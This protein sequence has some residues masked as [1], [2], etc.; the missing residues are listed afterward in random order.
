MSGGDV[1]S[2][3]DEDALIV[4]DDE[5]VVRVGL[6]PDD[7]TVAGAQ[8]H[9][10]DHPGEWAVSAAAWRGLEP[11]EIMARAPYL[12]HPVL[13]AAYAGD[14]RE[15]GFEV[16]SDGRPHVNIVLPSEPYIGDPMLER[17]R[18]VLRYEFHNPNSSEGR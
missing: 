7:R 18:N 2:R 8:V 6:S 10:A 5:W 14:L 16:Y 12:T 11:P 15:A 1:E 17:L 13:R 9:E 4:N 3:N